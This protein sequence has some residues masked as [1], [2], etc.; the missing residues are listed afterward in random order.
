MG[1]DF[2]G[3]QYDPK[4]LALLRCPFTVGSLVLT[5]CFSCFVQENARLGWVTSGTL[6]LSPK[7]TKKQ[8]GFNLRHLM[9]V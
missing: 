2:F 1:C 7:A 6:G 5:P 8:T 4:A 9:F 3:D